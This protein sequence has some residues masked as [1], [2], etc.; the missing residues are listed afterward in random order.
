MAQTPIHWTALIA[1]HRAARVAHGRMRDRALP[2]VERDEATI[3][4]GRALDQMFL[5]MEALSEEGVLAFLS[6]S[7][8]RKA[9]VTS[10]RRVM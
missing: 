7:L 5:S 1:Q 8:S 6:A 9:I 2:Q 4:F 10:G 3:A